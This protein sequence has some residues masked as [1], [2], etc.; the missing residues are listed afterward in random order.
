MYVYIYDLYMCIRIQHCGY[1][2]YTE[3]DRYVDIHGHDYI[4]GT[5]YIYTL[6]Y[7]YGWG[8]YTYTCIYMKNSTVDFKTIMLISLD[9]L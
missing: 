9:A 6:I 3:I 2:Y 7:I 4:L 5:I 1:T 8:I